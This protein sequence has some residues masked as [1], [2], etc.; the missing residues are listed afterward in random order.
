MKYYTCANTSDGVWD[1][2]GDNVF[3]VEDIIELKSTNRHITDAVLG[4]FCKGISEPYD[5]IIAPGSKGLKSGVILNSRKLAVVANFSGA[6]KTVNLD[7]L[8]GDIHHLTDT[9]AMPRAMEHAYREAKRIHDDWEKIYI[10]NMD[11]QRID[12]FS[13]GVIAALAEA[14]SISGQA[15]I[16]KRFFGTTTTEG[17]VNFIDG[18]TFD[19]SRRYFIKG[20][21]GTGKSTFLRKLSQALLEKGFDIEQYYCSFDPNSLDMVVSRE[22]SFGVF[23]S[24]APHEKFPEREND[25]ILDFYIESGLSGVDE[26]YHDELAKIKNAYDAKIREGNESFKTAIAMEDEKNIKALSM[27]KETELLKACELIKKETE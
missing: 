3:D 20:R 2:T 14:Q 6:S 8:F 24:T 1:F 27:I 17:P 23:D 18:L 19:L 7:D 9:L 16:Y 13:K 21:P 15:K 22:L 12:L 25:I 4:C 26:R 5:E 10:E 11:F